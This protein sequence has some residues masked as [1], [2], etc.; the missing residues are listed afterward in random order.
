MDDQVE[1]RH[2]NV[3]GG[4]LQP[5]PPPRSNAESCEVLS[6]PTNEQLAAHWAAIISGCTRVV[7]EH[8]DATHHYLELTSSHSEPLPPRHLARW[9]PIL[10]GTSLKVVAA[11]GGCASST[12]A[13]SAAHCLKCLGL[14]R[15]SREAPMLLVMMAHASARLATRGLF[16]SERLYSSVV[17]RARRPDLALV[18]LLSPGELDV[19]RLRVDGLSHRE[20]AATRSTS[21]RTIANQLASA[22][23][24]LRVSGRPELLA[25]LVRRA[26]QREL[27]QLA[28]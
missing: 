11:N 24:K 13:C 12:V 17:I 6:S 5:L 23:G 14:E 15:T 18:S 25:V 28:Q 7:S 21:A 1:L 2:A 27:Q 10:M 19:L 16:S 8:S 9:L 20:I 22:Y 3:T 26:N 4:W